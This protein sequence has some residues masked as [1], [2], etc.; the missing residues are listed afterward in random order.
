MP[1]ISVF[2]RGWGNIL[3]NSFI[4]NSIE[5]VGCPMLIC[6]QQ[7]VKANVFVAGKSQLFLNDN[8]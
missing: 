5:L 6:A 3:W 8:K 7:L 2:I 1:A 4:Y